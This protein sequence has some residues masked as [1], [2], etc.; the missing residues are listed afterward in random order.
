MSA[1][2]ETGAASLTKGN[3]GSISDPSNLNLDIGY[4]QRS[5][6]IA[7]TPPFAQGCIE[8]IVLQ[9]AISEQ[10]AKR[11]GFGQRNHERDGVTWRTI[12]IGSVPVPFLSHHRCCHATTDLR[13]GRQ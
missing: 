1:L 6:L 9:C 2:S 11:S 5:G 10:W 13:N 3:P 7:G 4:I 8:L 12:A